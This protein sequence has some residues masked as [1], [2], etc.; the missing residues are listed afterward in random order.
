MSIEALLG[1]GRHALTTLG[2]FLAS[3]GFIEASDVEI[4]VGAIAA[5]IGVALSVFN[6]RKKVPNA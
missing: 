5:L 1:L 4:A 3:K 6:K 2:G